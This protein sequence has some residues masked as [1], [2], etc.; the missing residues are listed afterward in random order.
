M[1]Y[2]QTCKCWVCVFHI[3][4]LKASQAAADGKDIV[5]DATSS[6]AHGTA[7]AADVTAQAHGTA[8]VTEADRTEA[9]CTATAADGTADAADGTADSA[10]GTTAADGVAAW[11]SKMQMAQAAAAD[12]TANATAVAAALE[13]L[14]READ[15][16]DTDAIAVPAKATPKLSQSKMLAKSAATLGRSKMLAQGVA[17]LAAQ[18]KQM[19]AQLVAQRCEQ[20]RAQEKKKLGE[21]Q[22]RQKL[23]MVGTPQAADGTAAAGTAADGEGAATKPKSV[24]KPPLRLPSQSKFPCQPERSPVKIEPPV[25]VEPGSFLHLLQKPGFKSASGVDECLY[26]FVFLLFICG[27]TLKIC[28][29]ALYIYF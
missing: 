18:E 7:T 5:A 26:R 25:K 10:D 27:E 28:V 16:M 1:L 24:S 29:T 11:H 23:V 14:C 8:D 12:G 3:K 15:T 6:S 19:K 4:I 20:K 22:S 2:H 21:A 17:K 9:D 13:T